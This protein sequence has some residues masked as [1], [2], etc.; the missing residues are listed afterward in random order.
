MGANEVGKSIEDLAEN[1]ES[2]QPMMAG[3]SFLDAKVQR[4]DFSGLLLPSLSLLLLVYSENFHTQPS[5][6]RDLHHTGQLTI[7][8]SKTVS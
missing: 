2:L 1:E 8:R 7:I 3:S 4:P 6:P 5:L